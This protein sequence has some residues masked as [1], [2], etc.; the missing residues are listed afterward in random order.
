M[1]QLA[2]L[3]ELNF[4]VIL[5]ELVLI[6][7]AML[8]MVVDMFIG[9]ERQPNPQQPALHQPALHQPDRSRQQANL[10]KTIPWLALV[11]VG[12]TAGIS[13]WLWDHPVATFQQMAIL[14]QFAVSVN[15][16][17]LIAAAL[18]ILLSVNYIPRITT[19]IGEYYTLM[20]LSVAGMMMMGS[21]SDLI[22]LFLALEIFSLAL[23]ILCGL[24][25][26]NPRSTEASMK[27]F[28]LGA[29]ASTFFV[30]GA[31]LIYGATGSTQYDAIA[32]MLF[33]GQSNIYLLY[34]G[35]ALM[36]VGFGF[37]ISLVPFHMWTPD[38]YQGTPTPVVAFMSVGTKTASVAAFI[39]FLLVAVPA[40]QEIWG[41]ALA[42]I[43]VLTMTL[44]NLAAL[45]QISLKRMLAYSTIAHAGYILVGL[46][47]GT[48]AGANAALFYLFTYAFMNIGAFAIVIAL[49]R[50]TDDDALQTRASGLATRL[51]L[52]AAA[53][54]I[55]M[56]SLS[57][58]PPLAGFFG[59][60]FVF[61]A[62]VDGGW[63][64]LAVI[65]MLNSAIAAYYYLRVTVA[66]YFEDPTTET[67]GGEQT[68]WPA[69]RVGVAVAAVLT[70][71]IGIYPGLWTGIFQA[72]LG[73]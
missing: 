11:G 63:V 16:I 55:F 5:P 1:Y 52:L 33:G 71:V 57:G 4:M 25:R 24:N 46:V 38:V 37:K 67:A 32:A 54:A 41:W 31:A 26:Q 7:V 44:G 29:F 39:R 21:A 51:P 62:A 70:I 28:L 66:M 10:R 49:E 3:P 72:A 43:A 6:I 9:K 59:K 12:I 8:I 15:L 53:M 22:T 35:L 47:P 30:Y 13:V 18:G 17:V 48:A 69:L 36:L 68:T 61:K 60:F 42:V 34:P 19:Q 2:N 40:Q 73:G 58:I 27:Y 20:L 50:A 45:R 56:F 64:W 23:Y 65:G 14:D